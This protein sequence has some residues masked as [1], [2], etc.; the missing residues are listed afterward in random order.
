MSG[1]RVP[2][3]ETPPATWYPPGQRRQLCRASRPRSVTL[4]SHFVVAPGS[5]L[6]TGRLLHGAPGAAPNAL[7]SWGQRRCGPVWTFRRSLGG[8]GPGAASPRPGGSWAITRSW[9]QSDRVCSKRVGG[10]SRPDRNRR[11]PSG[12]PDHQ[13]DG[14]IGRTVWD[15]RL[16]PLGVVRPVLAAAPPA[17]GMVTPLDVW[18]RLRG[19]ARTGCSG[20]PRLQL[21]SGHRG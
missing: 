7:E 6:R 18:Q 16:T 4:S 21:G 19:W 2:A 8:G 17:T 14:A 5:H 1:M 10:R 11:L 12:A 9:H 3:R 15:A 20:G 13:P